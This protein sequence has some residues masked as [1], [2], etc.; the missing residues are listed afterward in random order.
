M[1]KGKNQIISPTMFIICLSLFLFISNT[2]PFSQNDIPNL[3][4]LSWCLHRTHIIICK[5]YNKKIGDTPLSQ[6]IL[7]QCCKMYI[8]TLCTH[9][10]QVNTRIKY[11]FQILSF[12]LA[13]S[14][15]CFSFNF[16]LRTSQNA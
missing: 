4:K 14:V 12:E 6:N 11:D 8:S 9:L 15:R 10:S 7:M 3:A 16:C 1:N 13:T 5:G 2:Y